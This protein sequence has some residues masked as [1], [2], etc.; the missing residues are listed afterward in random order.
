MTR[1]E[2]WDL[3]L[4]RFVALTDY[5][6][7]GAIMSEIRRTIDLWNYE[8]FSIPNQPIK[9]IQGCSTVCALLRNMST[10]PERMKSRY[11]KIIGLARIVEPYC[12]WLR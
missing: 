8:D 9:Y 10:H 1:R 12:V 2:R 3:A 6:V 5:M 7:F 11:R 4:G